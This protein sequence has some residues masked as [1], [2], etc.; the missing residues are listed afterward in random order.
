MKSL[1]LE[2]MLGKWEESTKSRSGNLTSNEN[3][4]KD[5]RKKLLRED[6]SLINELTFEKVNFSYPCEELKNI[7]GMNIISGLQKINKKG[8][9]TFFRAI[10]FPTVYRIWRTIHKMGLSTSNY[11]QERLLF[12]YGN[13]KYMTK[14]RQIQQDPIFWIQPQERVIHGVPIFGLVNDAIQIH[15]AY[16]N[17]IDKVLMDV[18]HLPLE[19]IKSRKVKLT[20]NTAIDVDYDNVERNYEITNF[21]KRKNGHYIDYRTLR[22]KGIDLNE[23]YITKIPFDLKGHREFGIEQKFFILDIYRINLHDIQFQK[24]FNNSKVLRDNE[25]FLHGFFGDHNIFGRRPSEYL[26]FECQEVKPTR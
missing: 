11:E 24:L 25:Y 7:E 19:L 13:D 4:P 22:A 8:C 20:A 15:R 6:V 23:M 18:I 2:E 14:R 26:P 21:R 1:S 10:R 17:E 3:L 12:L 5:I 16:R 9:L